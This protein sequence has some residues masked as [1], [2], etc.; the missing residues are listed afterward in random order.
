MKNQYVYR[1]TIDSM[2]TVMLVLTGMIKIPSF[3][4]GAEFQ[5]SAPFAIGIAVMVGFGRY[6]G[7]GICASFIQLLLGTQTIW[8]V[9]IAMIF[10]IVAGSII[11]LFPKNKLA[12]IVA[13]PMG[14]IVARIVFAFILKVPAETLLLAAIPGMIFTAVLVVIF[15]PTFQ[16]L[17]NK[18]QQ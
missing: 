3:I 14:T 18:L 5:V 9:L 4:P 6:L 15:Q 10:R 12:M 13:G 8:N 16:L 11:T 2:L 1:L 7:I 17:K